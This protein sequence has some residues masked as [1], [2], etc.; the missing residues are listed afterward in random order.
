MP[1]PRRQPFTER[2]SRTFAIVVTVA[3]IAASGVVVWHFVAESSRV[4]WL[5][6]VYLIFTL[7]MSLICA[8]AYGLD[9]RRAVRQTRRISER[10]LHTLEL[11]GGWPGAV[12]A[13][14]LF[15]HKT[16][17]TSYRARFWLIVL[18]HLA[19]LGVG[20]YL[21]VRRLIEA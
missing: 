9:K 6:V 17:K 7:A 13:R 3:L 10:R 15:R 8:A 16:R 20:V 1:H 12:L 19:V 5:L 14:R 18:L 4:P 2:S 11:T 21:W